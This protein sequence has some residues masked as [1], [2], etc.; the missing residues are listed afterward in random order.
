MRK[1][2]K[3]EKGV[4]EEEADSETDSMFLIY[5]SNRSNMFLSGGGE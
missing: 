3:S 1:K 2:K 4:N 5:A